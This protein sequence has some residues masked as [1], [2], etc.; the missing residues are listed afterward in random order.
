MGGVGSGGD[1]RQA[2]AGAVAAQGL[3]FGLRA[4]PGCWQPANRGGTVW[5]PSAGTSRL[6]AAPTFHPWGGAREGIMAVQVC[7]TAQ[8]F[9]EGEWVSWGEVLSPHPEQSILRDLKLLSEGLAQLYQHKPPPSRVLQFGARF[10]RQWRDQA[11][12]EHV[13][14][15]EQKIK[16]ERDA[17]LAWRLPHLRSNRWEAR[18]RRGALEAPPST[19]DAYLWDYLSSTGEGRWSA[20]EI[21]LNEVKWFDVRLRDRRAAPVHAADSRPPI[22]TTGRQAAPETISPQASGIAAVTAA[23]GAGDQRDP[24]LLAFERLRT[25]DAWPRKVSGR[26]AMDYRVLGAMA[27]IAP[28]YLDSGETLKL[29]ISIS[30]LVTEALRRLEKDGLAVPV[31]ERATDHW[32]V[33]R[34][35]WADKMRALAKANVTH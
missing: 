18:G 8:A 1:V 17:L 25:P 9:G 21:I 20:S 11:A 5:P 35:A 31:P 24:R 26:A 34:D 6:A 27:A 16:R 10:I 13:E 32:K 22:E 4:T 7:A 33:V 23:A 29:T 28:E 15:L 19:I 30:N 14:W 3:G 12:R 2:G